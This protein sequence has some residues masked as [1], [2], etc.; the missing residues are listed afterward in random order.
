MGQEDAVADTQTIHPHLSG[1]LAPVRSE[2]EFEMKVVG[3]IPDALA[4]AVCQAVA[5][6]QMLDPMT[7]QSLASFIA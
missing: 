2:D 4:G 1:V 5:E 6:L 3:R 7:C